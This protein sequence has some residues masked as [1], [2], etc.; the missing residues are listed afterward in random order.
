MTSILSDKWPHAILFDLDGTLVDTHIDFTLM[1]NEML[2]LARE[3]GVLDETMPRMDILTIIDTSVERLEEC[4][5]YN[6][7]AALRP[8]AFEI[9]KEIEMRHAITAIEV[10]GARNLLKSLRTAGILTGIVTRNCRAAS[11]LSMEV[12]GI[13]VDV[14]VTREDTNRHKP[15]PDP[16]FIALDGLNCRPE[17]AVMIGDHPMDVQ[18]GKSA[19]CYTVGFLREDRHDG[20]FDTVCPDLIIK[21]LGELCFAA[22]NIHS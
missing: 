5:K 16:V 2:R 22:N 13:E 11:L 8:E 3:N 15:L 9:L 18:S 12:V 14:M 6:E 20:F 10:P 7:A 19:G 21:S 1:R 4:H 17:Q